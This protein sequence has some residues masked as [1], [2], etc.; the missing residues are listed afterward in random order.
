[1]TAHEPITEL[2]KEYSSPTATPISW[3]DGRQ[4]LEQAE[5]YWIAT[6]R[7]DGRPHVTP[8][9]G[10][11]LDDAL[12]F[13]TGP[14]ERKAQNLAQNVHCVITTGCNALNEGLD[15]V[16]EGD[17]VEIS[18]EATLQRV[19]DAFN[20]KYNWGYTVRDGALQG[21][22]GKTLAFRVAPTKG[23]GYGKGEP[24]SATRWRF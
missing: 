14:E 9:I 16:M 18:D 4:R 19:A 6:V 11:W 24:F 17:A 10:L 22:G 2:H 1:M 21:N 20:A 5:V 23:F 15:L 13:S 3:A 7:P 8:M 12:Y